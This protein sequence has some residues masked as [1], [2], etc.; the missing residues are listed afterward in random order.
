[1][2][3]VPSYVDKVYSIH[4][5]LTQP[6]LLQAKFRKDSYG[7]YGT[8]AALLGPPSFSGTP[9]QATELPRFLQGTASSK[10]KTKSA[11]LAG[12]EKDERGVVVA[13]ADFE[14]DAGEMGGVVRSVARKTPCQQKV[15]GDRVAKEV[16]A[17]T[18]LYHSACDRA[19]RM[20]E[21][22]NPPSKAT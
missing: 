22:T 11:A 10:A 3:K 14:D 17:G 20:P 1:L 15:A 12:G 18:S 16:R 4:G 5:T 7:P 6:L 2:A 8:N 9:W 21:C 13:G 19:G